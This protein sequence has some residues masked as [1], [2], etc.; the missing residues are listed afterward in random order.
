M[1]VLGRLAG[2]YLLVGLLVLLTLSVAGC[3][4]G[5]R[6]SHLP[7]AARTA[8]TTAIYGDH[9]ESL[10][11][12]GLTRTY[13]LHVPTTYEPQHPEPL[14]LAL[15]GRYGDGKGM[16]TLTHLNQVADQYGFIVVYPDGYQRSW[17]DGR[18]ASNADKAGVDDVAFLAALLAALSASYTIDAQRIYVTGISN[19][20]FMAQ[21]LGCDFAAK[22]AAIAVDAATLPDNLAARCAPAHPLAVLFFNGTADPLV[23]YAGGVV[24]GDRGT[25]LSASQTA[26]TW[27]RLA[28][29]ASTATAATTTV[30]TSVNDGTSVSYVTYTGCSREAEAQFYTITNGGHTWPG[31]LQYLPASLVGKTTRNLDAS[32]TLWAF[33]SRFTLAN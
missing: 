2:G 8:T 17:A 10:A 27:A 16:A 12:G 3:S 20:G 13:T 24:S 23:P 33:V 1:K 14:L 19:G 9:T 28:G 11:T 30:P 22:I 15:H 6:P 4:V 7:S 21:R 26:A 31:G 25:V 5:Q 32:Q 29:C 18:G